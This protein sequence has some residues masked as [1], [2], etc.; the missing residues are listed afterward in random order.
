[1]PAWVLGRLSISLLLQCTMVAVSALRTLFVRCRG[2]IDDDSLSERRYKTLAVRLNVFCII[3]FVCSL[4]WVFAS[5]H[6]DTEMS[7]A[8]YRLGSSATT[9]AV[10]LAGLGWYLCRRSIL[11]IKYALYW[12]APYSIL[13]FWFRSGCSAQGIGEAFVVV[14]IITAVFF[15]LGGTN[16][17]VL[18]CV[19]VSV[20][21]TAGVYAV[22]FL[23]VLKGEDRPAW[24]PLQAT[25]SSAVSLSWSACLNLFVQVT[26]VRS[27]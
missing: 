6:S 18:V 20:V 13:S 27:R 1:M 7:A 14:N 23:E 8:F 12:F 2:I 10:L 22:L 16:R 9:L 21:S 3:T 26:G 24:C 11:L 5:M 17:E 25:A 4:C 19:M 15:A